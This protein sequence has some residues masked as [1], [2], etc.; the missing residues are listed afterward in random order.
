MKLSICQK[1]LKTNLSDWAKAKLH[2]AL[3]E[4]EWE[5]LQKNKCGCGFLCHYFDVKKLPPPE[6]EYYLEHF[7]LADEKERSQENVVTWMHKEK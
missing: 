2:V 6:C 7:L 4:L 1:C 5:W 3:A